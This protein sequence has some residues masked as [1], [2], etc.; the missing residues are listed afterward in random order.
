MDKEE[1]KFVLSSFRPCGSDVDDPTFTD[2]L[3][4]AVEDQELSEWLVKERSFDRDFGGYLNNVQVPDSLKIQIQNL[5]DELS[6]DQNTHGDLQMIGALAMIQPPDG[7]KRE[8]LLAMEVSA[9]TTEFSQSQKNKKTARFWFPLAAAAVIAIATFLGV[10]LPKRGNLNPSFDI[11]KVSSEIV[12][13]LGQNDI[14]LDLKEDDFLKTVSW[15]SEQN[16]PM[17]SALPNGMN[18]LGLVGCK[19][20]NVE[21]HPASLICFHTVDGQKL[22]LVVIEPE[23]LETFKDQLPLYSEVKN[24][25]KKCPK[26]GFSMASWHDEKRF[27]LLF[28]KTLPLKGFQEVF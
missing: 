2:A 14:K 9:K 19:K 24:R 25:C 5:F 18:N 15:A 6:V 22:D 28:S 12:N 10:I 16:I 11:T 3:R 20:L 1:V 7:L 27:Y 4:C 8:I 17:P 21:G 13:G 26:T 23:D